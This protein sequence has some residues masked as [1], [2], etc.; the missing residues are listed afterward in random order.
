V[1]AP[2]FS[3]LTDLLARGCGA[4]RPARQV[5]ISTL[6]HP[7]RLVPSGARGAS[8]RDHAT[9]D[10]NVVVVAVSGGPRQVEGLCSSLP[11]ATTVS[12]LLGDGP[13]IDKGPMT[14]VPSHRPMSSRKGSDSLPTKRATEPVIP[15]VRG[16]MVTA[17]RR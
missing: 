11:S 2:P 15:G 17:A 10:E 6:G 13:P 16:L 8:K 9:P 3:D 14:R 7:E 1:P 4:E 5:L 12:V